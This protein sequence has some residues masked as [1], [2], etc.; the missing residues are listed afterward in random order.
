MMVSI[1][2][3]EEQ[4]QHY[5]L[6]I[7]CRSFFSDGVVCRVSKDKLVS[8]L[9]ELPN[10]DRTLRPYLQQAGDEHFGLFNGGDWY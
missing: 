6:E 3:T 9:K 8:M 5:G 2:L 10:D 7:E 4:Q 1:N